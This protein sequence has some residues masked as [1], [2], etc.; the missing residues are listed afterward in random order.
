MSRSSKGKNSMM[1]MAIAQ[2]IKGLVFTLRQGSEALGG[3]L[4]SKG[5]GHAMSYTSSRP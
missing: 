5:I 2:R 1:Q 3:E 4:N